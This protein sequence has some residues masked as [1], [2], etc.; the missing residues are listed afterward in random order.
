MPANPLSVVFL[1]Q[2]SLLFF[3]V[4]VVFVAFSQFSWLHL[5]SWL[6]KRSSNN[7]SKCNNNYN[8]N[9]KC[10]NNN[11]KSCNNCGKIAGI[12]FDTPLPCR[13]SSY[14]RKDTD[15]RTGRM[16][17]MKRRRSAGGQGAGTR[18]FN[19]DK[20]RTHLNK[21]HEIDGPVSAMSPG[22]PARPDS[23]WALLCAA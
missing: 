23:Q 10:N 5:F 9:S 4:V 21:Y 1:P 6:I 19:H 22:T 2:T 3:F 14:P 7:N 13:N 16:R 8:S 15:T 18:P 11:K 20:T 17:Q 12:D